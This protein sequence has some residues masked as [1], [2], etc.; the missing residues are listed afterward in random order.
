MWGP[1]AVSF[2]VPRLLRD[3]GGGGGWDTTTQVALPA[4][5]LAT[6]CPGP[7]ETIMVFR[8]ESHDGDDS[9]DRDHDSFLFS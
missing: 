5:Q 6:S 4:R 7:W 3:V 8:Q 1:V 2:G 9:D